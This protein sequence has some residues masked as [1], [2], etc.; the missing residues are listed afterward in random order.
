VKSNM[1]NIVIVGS[2][3]MDLVVQV[4]TIPKPGETVLGNNFATFPGGKGANQ[5]VA[6]ARLGAAVTMIGQVGA[7]TYGE[8]LID[9]LVTEGVK[10]DCVFSDNHNATGVAMISVDASGQN[11]I[12]VASGANF[13]LTKEHI[14]SA[15]EKLGDIDIL[16][17]P[18]ETPPD[19]IL[20]AARLAKRQ[21]VTIVLNPAPARFLDAELLSQVDVLVPNEHEIF[22]VSEYYLSSNV[23]VI[24]VEKAAR[25]IIAQGVN[26]VVTTQGSKGVSIVEDSKDEVLLPSFTVDVLDTTAA[27]DAFVAALAVGIGE[28]KS[29]IE[30]SYFANSAGALTVTK[31]G[32]QP[33]LPTRAEV[34]EFLGNQEAQ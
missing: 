13:T 21:G 7:D 19:T 17:M 5:A 32:A 31:L 26:A 3:N 11:S 1:T 22:Q 15:W 8:S 24:E 12:A 27:G 10:V 16:I 30:A 28:G 29:L 25:T 33:S 20:E 18:L 9:N 14:R 4:P 6:A 23:E 2:L 34:N